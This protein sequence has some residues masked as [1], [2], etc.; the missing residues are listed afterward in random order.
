MNKPL[1]TAPF[2]SILIET[3]KTVR[4]CCSWWGDPLGDLK[5]EN[6]NDIL[7]GEKLKEVQG[8][9]LR[10]EWPSNCQDCKNREESYGLSSRKQNYEPF[11]PYLN[12]NKITYLE[13]NSSNVCNL[14]CVGCNPSWSSAWANFRNDIP[15]WKEFRHSNGWDIG[16]GWE[17]RPTWTIHPSRPDFIQDVFNTLD[18]SSLNRLTFKGGE[19]FLNKEN[20]L[21]LEKLDSLDLLKNIHVDMTTNGTQM[22]DKFLNLLSKAKRVHFAISIDAVG[23]L[24]QYI[25]FDPK[26]PEASH[27]DN[28]KKNIK[29]YSR[30]ENCFGINLASSVQAHNIFRLEDL[31]SW[32]MDEINTINRDNISHRPV[33]NHF[34]LGPE[35]VTIKVFTEKTRQALTNYYQSLNN[36]EIYSMVIAFLQRP[37][38]GDHWHNKFITYTEALDKTRPKSFLELVPEAA[39]EL[40]RLPK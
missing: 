34:F 6:I 26:N 2:H 12:N 9:M 33:F 11:V 14:V 7:N 19:P 27:T 36:P 29:E 38:S 1:C 17:G 25:R 10:G 40:I 37:Y 35:E 30:L 3:D 15:W 31:R 20:V 28:I 23:E 39:D 22:S 4:P 13:F 8:Q 18:F 24:N 5:T 32:W 16:E 21:L